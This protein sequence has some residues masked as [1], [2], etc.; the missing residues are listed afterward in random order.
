MCKHGEPASFAQTSLFKFKEKKGRRGKVW[1]KDKLES[2]A[3][4]L[5][6]KGWM[7]KFQR[8]TDWGEYIHATENFRN[9][10]SQQSSQEYPGQ[11]VLHLVAPTKQEKA[12][13]VTDITQV[14]NILQITQNHI[15]SSQLTS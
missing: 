14:N 7:E 3:E 4:K 1:N 9:C 13:W 11:V 2:L 8:R 6:G 5:S 12:A 15:A 10:N